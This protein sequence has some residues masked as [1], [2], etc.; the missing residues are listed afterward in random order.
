MVTTQPQVVEEATRV[1]IA[2]ERRPEPA[3]EVQERE[4]E[5]KMFKLGKSLSQEMQNQI[6]KVLAR[7]LNAFSWST[8]DMLGIDPDFLCHLLTVDPK[9]RP[10]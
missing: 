4:I 6:V 5:G 1:E 10:I 9:V 8:S 7:H 2:R 3:S